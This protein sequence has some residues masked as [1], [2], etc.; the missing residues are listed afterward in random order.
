MQSTCAYFFYFPNQFSPY[1]FTNGL[2]DGIAD[3][4][5]DFA[6]DPST[7]PSYGVFEWTPTSDSDKRTALFASA[8]QPVQSGTGNHIDDRCASGN[9]YGY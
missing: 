3:L 8:D 4:W 7:D 1:I 6:Y 9:L 5:L 2:I